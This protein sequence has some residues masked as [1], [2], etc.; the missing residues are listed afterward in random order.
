[1]DGRYAPATPYESA[2][3][4]RPVVTEPVRY[5]TTVAPQRAVY[6]EPQPVYAPAPPAY[7]P[8][9]PAPRVVYE[10]ARPQRSWAKTALVIGG[11]A[12][13][14]AGLGAIFGGKK[15]ALIGAAL[16]GGASSVYEATKR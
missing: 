12:G 10:T 1:M 7:A 13:A 5:R 3:A 9:A 14:G 15:G 16:G 4:L 8:A 11:S 2:G 6:T